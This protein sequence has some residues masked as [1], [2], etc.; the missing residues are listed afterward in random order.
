M[1]CFLGVKLKPELLSNV[2]IAKKRFNETGGDIKLVE[3]ENLH[4]TVKFLGE[5]D[6][7]RAKDVKCVGNVLESYE[8][9]DIE[10]K[11]CGVFPSRN[12]IKVIWLGVGEGGETFKKMISEIDL[13]LSKVGFKPEENEIIPHLT[14]GRVKSGRAKNEILSCLGDIKEEKFGCMRVDNVSLFKSK[15][16]KKGPVYTRLERYDI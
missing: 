10:V 2:K 13:E 12:Y 9:F 7:D 8:P 14:L 6:E 5:I 1:R 3:D 4:F 15:L 11:G 16:E